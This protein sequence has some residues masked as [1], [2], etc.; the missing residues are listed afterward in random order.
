[1]TR[2]ETMVFNSIAVERRNRNKVV[3][4]FTGCG[5]LSEEVKK[6][7]R[8]ATISIMREWDTKPLEKNPL[9]CT[10]DELFFAE[11]EEE[12]KETP[13][14]DRISLEVD[15]DANY[16][17]GRHE[18]TRQIVRYFRSLGFPVNRDFIGRVQVWVPQEEANSILYNKYTLRPYFRDLYDGWQIDVTHTGESRCS[19][20][21]WLDLDMGDYPFDVVAGT[22]VLKRF[23]VAQ[24]H[25]Q[26]YGGGRPIVNKYNKQILGL[27]EPRSSDTNKYCTKMNKIKGF[28]QKYLLTPDFQD[29]LDINVLNNGALINVNPYNIYSVDPRAKNLKYGDGFV[30]CR[31]RYDFVLHN[32]YRNPQ[33]FK[34]FFIS[35][36][37]PKSYSVRN[38]LFNILQNGIDSS[39][40]T[41]KEKEEGDEKGTLQHFTPL[42]KLLCQPLSWERT[43]SVTYSSYDTALAE[44]R[45]KLINKN[46]FVPGTNYLAIIISEIHRDD[47]VGSRHGLYYQM[48]ELLMKSG[49]TSQVIYAPNVG[50]KS[51]KYFLPNI[52]AAI[53]GK[54][55][56]MP[57]GVESLS[58]R[59][60][61]I[62][63][64]GASKQRGKK[65]Y[66]GT[67]FCFDKEGQFREFDS[68]QAED[69]ETLGASLNKALWRFTQQYNKPDRLII[70]YYKKL[71][72]REGQHIERILKQNRLECPVYVVNMVTAANDDVIAFDTAQFNLMPQS[73][74]FVRLRRSQYLLYNN[75]KYCDNG[76][77]TPIFPIKL[78]ITNASANSDES[79]SEETETEIITQVYQFCRLYWKSVSMQNVP[80]TIAYPALVAKYIQHFVD[81]ELPEFGKHNL[82]ML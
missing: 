8:F 67:A 14:G 41:N 38:R 77:T 2:N 70:H 78:T 3:D 54:E 47:P 40:V 32:P 64:I 74:T 80:I 31:P 55:Y 62:V 25:F 81:E 11:W 1:M 18:M 21:V 37:S 35:L 71:N 44:L 73:G 27:A 4:L 23:D 51:F 43:L 61:M 57:W 39:I 34:Y 22:E 45:E 42:A 26:L 10:S 76:Q 20:K 69:T 17:L 50:S 56:G 36:D 30:G 12:L 48:K 13:M 65:P 29:T 59:N 66:L 75:E 28:I 68:C 16:R 79:L 9:L 82:W 7:V 15:L 63:G 46:R 52:A 24:R 53:I 5:G 60:D 33:P 72:K 58:I 49:V 19:K 6:R